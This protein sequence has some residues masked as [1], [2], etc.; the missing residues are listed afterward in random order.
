MSEGVVPQDKASVGAGGG[1]RH[2]ACRA[3][4]G[5]RFGDMYLRV[6]VAKGPD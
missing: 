6:E 4:D 5:F 3:R 1:R 2:E